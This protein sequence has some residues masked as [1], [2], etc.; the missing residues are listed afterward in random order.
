M[1]FFIA[2]VSS[3]SFNNAFAPK[4]VNTA[5]KIIANLLIG[6]V[7]FVT[8]ELIKVNKVMILAQMIGEI[9]VVMVVIIVVKDFFF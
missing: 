1:N 4:N 5:D 2:F 3:S 6:D 9:A 7:I 8:S